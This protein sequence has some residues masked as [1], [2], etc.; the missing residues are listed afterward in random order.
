[1]KRCVAIQKPAVLSLNRSRLAIANEDGLHTLPMEDLAVVVLDHQ[2]IEV[3]APLL[4]R[5]GEAGVVL[6]ASGT[7]HLPTAILMPL[8]GSWLHAQVLKGQIAASLPTKKRL[9]QSI[10][11]EKIA[12]QARLLKEKTGADKGLFAM[13]DRVFSGDTTNREGAAA[14]IYFPALFGGGF[15]RRRRATEEEGGASPASPERAAPGQDDDPPLAWSSRTL[16]ETPGR[17]HFVNGCLN[18]GYAVL[19]AAV[20]RAVVLAGLHPALGLHHHN[21][22]NP[23]A[24]ADDLMEPLRVLADR[25]AWDAD[26]ECSDDD[27][28]PPVK[29]RLLGIL[30]SEV[31]WN[32]GRWPLDAALEA[33]AAGVRECL[34]ERTKDFAAP[35]A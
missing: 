14:G 11:K 5:L 2:A 1:M 3:T 24:L 29:R 32:G 12:S 19:R 30:A 34:L 10:V 8:H 7:K 13:A 18:Y 9:W 16:P 20:A 6:L 31:E 22:E 35:A 27:L 26:R 33:Y 15:V 28:T 4:G 23:F 21:R 25:A 17:E